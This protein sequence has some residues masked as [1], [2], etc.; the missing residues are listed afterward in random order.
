M[1][2]IL[3]SFACVPPTSWCYRGMQ[4]LRR[5]HVFLL[6]KRCL[7]ASGPISPLAAGFQ[8]PPPSHASSK[9]IPTTTGMGAWAPARHG[10]ARGSAGRHAHNVVGEGKCAL[11]T[12]V[13]TRCSAHWELRRFWRWQETCR[14][15]TLD[16][17]HRGRES[18]LSTHRDKVREAH[19][20]VTPDFPSKTECISYVC[21]DHNFTHMI[22]SWV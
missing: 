22:D 11:K 8:R 17:R 16:L 19:S 20:H 1:P 9:P 6:P 15:G 12:A 2:S 14:G 21:Q 10:S 7:A 4:G 18:H 13:P 5:Q 3:F